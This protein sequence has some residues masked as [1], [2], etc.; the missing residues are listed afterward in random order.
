MATPG[1]L[2]SPH[3][4]T[5]LP[6]LRIKSGPELL[7]NDPNSGPGRNP[8]STPPRIRANE[9]APYPP[10]TIPNGRGGDEHDVQMGE[11]PRG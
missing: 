4:P 10:A 11:N 8:S 7:T 1:S 9:G 6:I 2:Y 5:N 3:G